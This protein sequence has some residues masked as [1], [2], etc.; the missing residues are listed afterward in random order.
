MTVARESLEAYDTVDL[1]DRQAD[2]F[3]AIVQLHVEGNRPCDQDIADALDWP[4]NRVTGRRGELVGFGKVV[5]AG[6]KLNAYGKRVSVWMPV[7][8]QLQLVLG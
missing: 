2:V 7:P 5:K 6:K 1:T 8:E 4:I 3:R